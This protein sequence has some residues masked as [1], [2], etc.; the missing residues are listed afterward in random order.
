MGLVVP[1]S[2]FIETEQ[3]SAIPLSRLIKA[4]H[5]VIGDLHPKST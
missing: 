2:T 3:T 5:Q 1:R 4:F